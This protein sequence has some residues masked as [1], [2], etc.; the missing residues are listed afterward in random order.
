MSGCDF[1]DNI[2]NIG[3]AK[4]YKHLLKY[5]SLEAFIS[6]NPNLPTDMYNHITSREILTPK[7]S[8]YTHT[9]REINLDKERLATWSRDVIA[10]YNISTIYEQLIAA[11]GCVVPPKIVTYGAESVQSTVTTLSTIT[12]PPV[13]TTSSSLPTISNPSM[14]TISNSL[15]IIT[16]P[17]IVTTSSSLSTITNPSMVTT[18]STITNPP[19]AT[20]Y[21]PPR[22]RITLKIRTPT[23]TAQLTQSLE[24]L[25]LNSAP[26]TSNLNSAIHSSSSSMHQQ[27]PVPVVGGAISNGIFKY[28]V[29]G[30]TIGVL[31]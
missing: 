10:Q 14:V 23:S 8:G 13:V 2:P 26:D 27:A 29:N 11:T 19:V 15:Q 17:P 18:L 5:Q 24:Q 4:S 25:T 22:P 1:N 21:S 6:N 28:T 9:S 16:N 20:I 30:K 3:P 7:P 31:L 12:N